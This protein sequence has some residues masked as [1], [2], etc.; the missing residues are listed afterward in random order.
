MN[1]DVV[2]RDVVQYVDVRGIIKFQKKKFLKVEAVYEK[3]FE[4]IHIN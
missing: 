3:L 1:V 4:I 2:L